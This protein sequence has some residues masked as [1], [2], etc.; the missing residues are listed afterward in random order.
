L[1]T[2]GEKKDRFSLCFKQKTKGE[3]EEQNIKSEGIKITYFQKKNIIE[4]KK[5]NLQT[6][7]YKVTLFNMDGLPVGN[8]DI[9]D[10]LQLN[11]QLPITNLTS[12]IY[13]AKVYTPDGE[14]SKKIIIP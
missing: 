7:I 11:I 4:I 1:I 8:W 12:G 13:I 14:P 6:N 3:K 9:V 2:S 5:E 10:Q